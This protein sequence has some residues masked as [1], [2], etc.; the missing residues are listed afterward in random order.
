MIN[1]DNEERPAQSAGLLQ[2]SHTNNYG[3]GTVSKLPQSILKAEDLLLGYPMNIS[4][5]ANQLIYNH[6]KVKVR[7]IFLRLFVTLSQI[8]YLQLGIVF[9]QIESGITIILHF[10]NH[11]MNK[12]QHTCWNGLICSSPIELSHRCTD[13]SHIYITI[14]DAIYCI[15]ILHFEIEIFV[16]SNVQKIVMAIEKN[17]LVVK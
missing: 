4:V 9:L 2:A 14:I 5:S 13:A 1:V 12:V 17:N 15:L 11:I 7:N 10:L 8:F 16:I 6:V 3:V